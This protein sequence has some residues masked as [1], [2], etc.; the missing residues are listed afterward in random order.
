[1]ADFIYEKIF[2]RGEESTEYR[3]VTKDY[4]ETVEYGGRK[5]L[6]VNPEGLVLLAREAINDLSFFMRSSHLEKLRQIIDDPEASANDKFVA[7][8]MLKNSVISAEG[9]LP[10]CQDTGTAIVLAKK[11]EDVYTGAEDALYISKGIYETYRDKNL[12]F[13][14]II[15]LSMFEEK[16]SGTNLPA[17][18]EIYSDMGNAYEFLFIAKGG[19]SANKVFLYQQSKSLLNEESLIKFVKEKIKDI[20]TS[21]CPPYHLAIVI[22]GMSA[23]MTLKTVK[24]ASAGYLDNLPVTGNESGRA[25]RDIELEKIIEKICR[26]YGV[27]AQFG[28]KYFVHDVRV[29]RLPRHAASCPVGMG[30]SCSAHRNVQAKITQEGIFIEKLERNLERFMPAG[31]PEFGKP[32][33]VNLNRPVKEI[34]AELTKYPLKTRLNLTGTLI[35]A[36]DMAHA[37]IKKII[38]EGKP[39]PEYFKNHPIY[40]AGPAKTPEGM[41]SGSFGPT[42]A[43][44]MDDYVELFQS[45]GGSLVMIAKGE[46]SRKVVES[47]KKYGGFYLGTIGGPAAVLGKENI[48]SVELVDFEDLG[49]EAVRKIYVENM[50]AF[51]LIDDKGNNFFDEYNK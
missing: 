46:R 33:E 43:G 39:I 26:E 45:L 13:S 51:I 6:K 31:A 16:N 40:Y 4:V 5:I 44:R 29:I 49:M 41:I 18:I 28:G 23:E 21:A 48:K 42:T 36:R 25:F 22:G 10:W 12:R 1:M 3:L 24:M 9:E 37:R 8:T 50:P 15:P 2:Q 19:G 32:V 20:G 30:V 34:I 17:Q 38:N 47:C 27:G 35:V 11:G 14:Q 7:Y